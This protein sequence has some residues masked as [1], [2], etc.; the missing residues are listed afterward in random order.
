M[1]LNLKDE[2]KIADL[3]LKYENHLLSKFRHEVNIDF[4]N[5]FFDVLDQHNMSFCYKNSA[6]KLEFGPYYP[7]SFD[8]TRTIISL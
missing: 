8:T 3:I 7:S 5:E 1:D 4:F 6:Q 2:R